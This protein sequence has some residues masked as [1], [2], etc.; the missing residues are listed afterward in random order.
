MTGREFADFRRQYDKALAGASVVVLSGSLPQGLP[1]GAYATL[2]EM[3]AVAGVPVVLDTHGE[4]LLRGAAAGRPLRNPSFEERRPWP[5]GRL[6]AADGPDLAAVAAAA[7]QLR[8]AGAQAVVAS[9]GPVG[10]LAVS[11]DGRWLA[12]PAR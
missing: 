8:T 3:A 11:G 7:D 12:R 6:S 5:A 2:I 1:A 10:L 4:A 9:M